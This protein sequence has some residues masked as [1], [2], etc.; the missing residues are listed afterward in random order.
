MVLIIVGSFAWRYPYHYE[1]YLSQI[2][3]D[4]SFQA[5]TALS[6]HY[7]HDIVPDHYTLNTSYHFTLGEFFLHPK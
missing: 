5:F 1:L 7:D 3:E 2:T 4:L 6:D